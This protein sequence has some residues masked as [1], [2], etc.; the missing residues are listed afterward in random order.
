MADSWI[1][2]TGYEDPSSHWSSETAAF[3]NDVDTHA[4]G[5]AQGL[6]VYC[7]FLE[8]NVPLMTCSKV[9]IHVG[10]FAWNRIYD[11][12]VYYSGA[13]HGIHEGALSGQVWN[14]LSVGST[15]NVTA[16]R[17]RGKGTDRSR[18]SGV[19]EFDFWGEA[20][21]SGFP[22]SLGMVIG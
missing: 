9:R 17:V 1:D 4:A 11:V 5:A 12:D 15:E 19:F 10:N 22:H 16:A 8:L 3:D 14:D 18:I 21:P 6:G 13:W 2:P 7:G 20:L